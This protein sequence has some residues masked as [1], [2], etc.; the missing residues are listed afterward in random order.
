MVAKKFQ[1]LEFGVNVDISLK[2]SHGVYKIYHLSD[3]EKIYVGSAAGI[4]KYGG[5]SSRWRSHFSSLKLG[6]HANYKLNDIISKYGLDGLKF[7]I[8]EVCP[9]EMCIEREQYWIDVLNPYLNIAKVAG[10][11]LGCKPSLEIIKKEV[12]RYYNMT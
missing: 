9:P 7:E 10:N 3:P 11:T 12:N 4:W 5:F 8:L 1:F 2:H 6:N